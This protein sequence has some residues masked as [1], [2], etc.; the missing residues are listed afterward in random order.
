MYML[1][2]DCPCESH[3]TYANCCHSIHVGQPAKTAEQLMRARYSAYVF[4]NLDFIESSH[5]PKTLAKTDMEAN[6]DWARSTTWLNLEILST[7]SGT[8][9]D[10][11]GKVEFRAQFE[12]QR[13]QNSHH[14]ISEFRRRKG[15]WY[16]SSGKSVE[17]R[18]IIN[19]VK[20]PGR[21]EPCLCGS[22][23]KYKKCCAQ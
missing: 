14:E 21:N 19:E 1:E 13:G 9:D 7:E 6:A 10:D 15:K 16:F 20:P 17:N 8:E 5:D 4:K 23:K 11:W 3:E 22:G 2:N 12:N 18:Q